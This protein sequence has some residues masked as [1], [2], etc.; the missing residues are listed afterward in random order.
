VFVTFDPTNCTTTNIVHNLL[1]KE[2]Q[3]MMA[4]L[5]DKVLYPLS[6]HP[7]FVP[8]LVME[9][10]YNEVILSLAPMFGESIRLSIAADLDDDERYRHLIRKGLDI[11]HAS[12]RSLGHEQKNILTLA[13]KLGSAIKIGGKL[14]TW[15]SCFRTDNMTADQK[16]CFDSSSAIIQNRLEYLI[17]GLDIQLLRVKG[18]RPGDNSR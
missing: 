6:Y 18:T 3:A 14:M 17:D 9:L 2:R 11:E 10:L 4:R 7:L 12:E 16:S 5:E 13:E 1:S 15:F 8:I